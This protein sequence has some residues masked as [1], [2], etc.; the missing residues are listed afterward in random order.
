MSHSPTLT[1]AD[2]HTQDLS[3]VQDELW[4][5]WSWCAAEVITDAE[6]M[7][8]FDLLRF[9]QVRYHLF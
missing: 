2:Q 9:W 7:A 5:L 6:Q 3:A 4:S 1:Q 8:K